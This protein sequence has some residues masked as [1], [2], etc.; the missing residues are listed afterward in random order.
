MAIDFIANIMS[1]TLCVSVIVKPRMATPVYLKVRRHGVSLKYGV[2][3]K[4]LTRRVSRCL[5]CEYISQSIGECDHYLQIIIM[6]TCLG[7]SG[8]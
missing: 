5:D 2:I 8:K 3:V 4:H 6:Y 1:L 7:S